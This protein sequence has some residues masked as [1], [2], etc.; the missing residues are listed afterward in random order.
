MELTQI[1]FEI[2]IQ[3]EEIAKHFNDLLI[4]Y[5]LQLMAGMGA[6]GTIASYLIG[7]KASDENKNWLI[8]VVSTWLLLLIVAAA[9][10]DLCYYSQLLLGAVAEIVDYE[11]R[12]PQIQISTRIK[13]YAGGDGLWAI[14]SAYAVMILPLMFFVGNSWKNYIKDKI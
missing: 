13:E 1:D 11:K 14:K 6:I 2:W 3:Y 10:I 4:Q 9:I 7:E 12:F 5:R 8:A